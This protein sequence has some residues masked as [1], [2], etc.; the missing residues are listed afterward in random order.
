MSP[1]PT[2]AVT[3]SRN[4]S[5]KQKSITDQA[6][7]N[8]AD[9]ASH[10]WQIVAELSDPSSASRYATKVRQNWATLLELLPAVDVVILWEPSRGDRTLATWAGFLDLARANGGRIHATSHARTY[11]PRRARDYR[12]L[13]EDGVDSAYESDKISERTRRGLAAS[14][15]AGHPHGRLAYGYRR[16]YDERGNFVEQLPDDGQAAIV[17]RI[18]EAVANNEPVQALAIQLTREGVATPRAGRVWYASTITG[19]VANPAYRPHPADPERG[20]RTH[21][22]RVQDQPAAWPPLVDERIWLAA[23]RVL[24]GDDDQARRERRD[25][26]PGQIKYLL[27]GNVEVMTA[28]CGSL[29]SGWHKA[30][31]RG[32]TYACRH[33]KCV[34]A[35]MPECDEYVTQLVCAR[36]ARKDV[37]RLWVADDAATKAAE[38][39]LARLNAELEEARQSFATPGGISAAALAMKEQSMAPAIEDAKR[40]A[41]P[42]G[43]P[44][45]ALQLI[46]AAKF[47]SER[48]RPAF[49][50]FPVTARRELVAGTFASLV[51]GPTTDRITRWTPPGERLAI[52]ADRI[53]HEW[54]RP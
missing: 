51:L 16:R 6:A 29:L 28:P 30:P 40:R 43:V 15:A 35:P 22:G 24:G 49:D 1:T 9:A 52:V 7:E 36:F 48:V 18:F 34:S 8:R 26:A 47:G 19:I 2:R 38:G 12:S 32:S 45:A 46:E 50:S 11:D 10:G 17:R 25:S 37:R 5:A 31:G 54:R 3:Y 20:T 27:S 53:E 33:D 4:S 14:M 23:N 42:A 13:A 44:L 41:Q 21:D 39:E